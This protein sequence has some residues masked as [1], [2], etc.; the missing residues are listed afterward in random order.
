MVL[1]RLVLVALLV[2]GCGKSLFDN[3]T[4]GGDDTPPGDAMGSADAPP[5][6]TSCEAPCIGDA[7]GNFDGTDT[8]ST[9]HWRYLDDTRDRMWAPMTGT[10][11]KT[12]AGMNKIAKCDASNP[13]A[14]ATLNGA[15]L[16]TST[17][18]SGTADPAIELTTT[19]TNVM[20]L[21]LRAHVPADGKAQVFRLY[22]GSREDVLFTATAMPGV[23]L[24][25]SIVV[26]TLAGDRFLLAM[27]PDAGGTPDVAVH[28][29]ATDTEMAWPKTCQYAASFDP[30]TVTATS[31][32]PQ[33]C[34]AT[35]DL[36][37]SMNDEVASGPDVEIAPT[38][39][40]GPYAE[41]GMAADFVEGR[42]F[43][44][45]VVVDRTGDTTTQLWVKFDSFV[46][47]L[48]FFVSDIDVTN[49]PAGGGFAIDI[50]IDAGTTHLEVIQVTDG[51]NPD[52]AFG[53]APYLGTGQ[54]H[55][56]RMVH[57]GDDVNVCLDGVKQF[58][59]Q[60]PA[61][62]A[63]SAKTIRL[64]RNQFN[65]QEALLVGQLDDVRIF[66]GALPCE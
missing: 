15:L 53:D 45:N 18:A 30:T 11:T 38:F 49:G 58:T 33:R 4:G 24:E 7:A 61:G 26:D 29:Y 6:Q 35:A 63:Q 50:Y 65:P 41:Q 1:N 37:T 13:G 9:G 52:Y 51:T 47:S 22:R 57:E 5:V 20:Q 59:F 42:Y 32:L 46:T 25:Q 19:E 28:L 21:S 16:F 23:T 14:C 40:A 8:G 66:K 3:N 44:S 12:G 2:C 31:K 36:L 54:W 55:F 62:S 43:D 48:A 39:A 60:V 56:V 27:A 64:G 17:G 34:S 10:M